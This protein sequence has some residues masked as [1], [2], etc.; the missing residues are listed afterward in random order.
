MNAITIVGSL[1]FASLTTAGVVKTVDRVHQRETCQEYALEFQEV[2]SGRHFH[3]VKNTNFYA[4]QLAKASVACRGSVP[5]TLVE[6]NRIP[7]RILD[8]ADTDDMQAKA[9]EAIAADKETGKI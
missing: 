3:D 1:V 5:A 6:M 9:M 7:P 8:A 2:A 4:L